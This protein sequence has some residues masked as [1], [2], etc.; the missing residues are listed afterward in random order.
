MV[1]FLCEVP[2]VR[3]TNKEISQ[4]HDQTPYVFPVVTMGSTVNTVDEIESTFQNVVRVLEE[5]YEICRKKATEVVVWLL[6]D[7]DRSWNIEVP[8]SL[9]VAYAMKGYSLPI[10]PMRD[11]HE[12]IL[13]E[14]REKGIEV[15]CSCFDGQWIKLATRDLNNRP[16][17]LLQLQRDVY[18]TACKEKRTVIVKKLIRESYY[19]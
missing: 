4:T 9:P 14:C 8:H 5:T 1:T 13:N 16:L 15:V 10:K 18:D 2:S 19:I 12:H 6:S 17:T 3:A 7:T 11:M